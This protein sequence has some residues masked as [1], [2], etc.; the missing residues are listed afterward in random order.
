MSRFDSL[1]VKCQH[2]LFQDVNPPLMTWD[3]I[4]LTKTVFF[5]AVGD[6]KDSMN[7]NDVMSA[8]ALSRNSFHLRDDPE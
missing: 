3:Q 7:F 4:G 8:N 6:R 2:H 5:P 1:R